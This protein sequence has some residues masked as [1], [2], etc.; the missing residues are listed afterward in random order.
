METCTRRR[1]GAE[2]VSGCRGLLNMIP[3]KVFGHIGLECT[4]V[5]GSGRKW[6]M[7]GQNKLKFAV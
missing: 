6:E 2:I 3:G 5:K 1:S 7:G 4:W